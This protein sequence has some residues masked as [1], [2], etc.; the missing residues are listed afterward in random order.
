MEIVSLEEVA[1]EAVTPELVSRGFIVDHWLGNYPLGR[2]F[3]LHYLLAPY[4]LFFVLLA[5]V[6]ATASIAHSAILLALLAVV[7]VQ[8]SAWIWALVGT[9][10]AAHKHVDTPGSSLRR[11]AVKTFLIANIVIVAL[12]PLIGVL[13]LLLKV[14]DGSFSHL[15]GD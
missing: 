2:S 13:A 4:V 7:L 9:Y 8:S 11:K 3:W 5:C 15:Q 12:S 10:R 6:L 14:L 1:T